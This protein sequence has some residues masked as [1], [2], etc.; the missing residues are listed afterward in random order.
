MQAGGGLERGE[1]LQLHVVRDAPE[2]L[3]LAPAAVCVG[4][5][6]LALL[7]LPGLGRENPGQQ[8]V[9]AACD[10]LVW[11]DPG[12]G[13]PVRRRWVLPGAAGAEQPAVTRAGR[14]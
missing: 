11:G 12:G 10:P 9:P 8:Q 6:S 4:R 5:A 13:S 2:S 14:Q 3:V 7:C 1:S